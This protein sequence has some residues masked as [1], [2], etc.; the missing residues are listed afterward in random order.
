MKVNAVINKPSLKL[1]NTNKSAVLSFLVIFIGV[2]SGAILYNFTDESLINELT[3]LFIGNTTDLLNNNK[4]ELFYGLI[5]DSLIYFALMLIFAMC[6]YGTPAVFII[7]FAKAMGLS[8]LTTDIYGSFGLEGIE[9]CL[10]ILFPGKFVLIFAMILLTQNCFINSNN[11]TKSINSDNN[12]VVDL[13]KYAI[14]TVVIS[15]LIV[16]S[17]IIDFVTM[18]S[19]SSLFE[20]G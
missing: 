14:R 19:F 5:V 20:F 17:A 16:V 15:G 11:I 1:N 4:P 9:Y 12:R 10:L 7:S 3:A 13:K 6:V 8:F 2:V 18:I